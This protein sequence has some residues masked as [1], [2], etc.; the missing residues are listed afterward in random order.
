MRIFLALGI[1]ALSLAGAD[2]SLASSPCTAFD[3]DSFPPGNVWFRLTPHPEKEAPATSRDTSMDL[4]SELLIF[5]IRPDG[6]LVQNK[7]SRF[8]RVLAWKL[9]S[10]NEVSTDGRRTWR[11]GC[12]S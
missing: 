4:Q 7:Q 10:R 3:K 12:A 9:L 11:A 2:P 1:L 6:V 5:G 8:P